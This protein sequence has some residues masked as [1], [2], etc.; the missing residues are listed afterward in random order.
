M[1]LARA[2]RAT[3]LQEWTGYILVIA[4]VISESGLLIGSLIALREGNPALVADLPAL[5]IP[6]V[7]AFV[8]TWALALFGRYSWHGRDTICAAMLVKL[9]PR[10][11]EYNRRS[12]EVTFM[13]R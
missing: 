9:A 11:P 2:F 4:P 1:S 8:F 3:R 5:T 13:E 6:L 10:D 7:S 12:L